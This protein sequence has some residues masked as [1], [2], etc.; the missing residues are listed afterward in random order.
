MVTTTTNGI[1]KDNLSWLVVDVVKKDRE[2]TKADVLAL[3]SQ[4]FASHVPQM[5]EELF[6]SYMYTTI[7]NVHPSSTSS[8]TDMRQK[9]TKGSSSA[10]KES[11]STKVTSSSKT[12]TA[13]KPKTY[14]SQPPIQDYDKWST[15]Q[16]VDKD[17]D[18]S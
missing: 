2:R 18:I 7:L 13:Q 9:T 12:T 8:I 17:E 14:A 3:V 1:M 15:A 10:Y 11:S 5:I 16:E 6:K 4:E